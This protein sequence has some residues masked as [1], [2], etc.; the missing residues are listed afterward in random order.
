MKEKISKIIDLLIQVTKSDEIVWKEAPPSHQPS[1][2]RDFIRNMV[3]VGED[4]TTFDMNISYSLLDDKYILDSPGM[5]IRSVDIPD[6][7]H[8]AI[9]SKYPN[10]IILRDLIKDKFC[11]DMDPNGKNIGDAFDKIYQGISLITIRDNKID[12]ILGK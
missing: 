7:L 8:Y 1:K 4:G 5:F 11:A 6:G 9:G 2:K 3:L 10:L 12:S